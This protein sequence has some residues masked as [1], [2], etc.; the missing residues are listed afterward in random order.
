MITL[1]GDTSTRSREQAIEIKDFKGASNTLLD[2]ARI[3]MNEAKKALNLM[4]V[5]DGLW[6]P[7]WGR[8]YYGATHAASIDGAYEFVKADG[9]TELITIAG[10][11]VYKST[12]GGAL[13]SVSGA[14]FTAGVQLYFLQ[15]SGYLYITNGVDTLARYDGSVLTTYTTLAAP[16]SLTASITGSGLSSGSFPLYAE[17]TALNDIG[18]TV[19]STEASTTVNKLRDNW[20]V[21]IDK[22]TWSWNTVV[23]ASRYQLY[24]ADESGDE[25]LLTS[26]VTNSFE[27]DGSL[28]LNPY[29]ETPI[30]NTTGAPKFKSMCVSGNR[31]WATNNPDSKFTVYFSGTGQFIDKF[32]DFYGG[33]YINLEKGGREMPTAVVHYQSGQG[34][35]RLTTL[36]RTP[37]GKGAVWQITISTATVGDVS[38]SVPSAVKVVGSFGT[39]SILGVVSTNND[40]LFPNRRGMFS[41]GP[42]KNYYGILRTNELT[43]KIRPTW[44]GLLGEK[45]GEIASYFYD[46]KVF[47]SVPTTSSGNNRTIIYDTER[48]NWTVD[49]SFGA[50]QWLEYTDSEKGNHLLYV[51]IDG[52]QLV[53]VGENIQGD[54]GTAFATDYTSGRIPLNKLWKDFLK[55]NKVFIKLGNPRGTINWEVGGTQRNKPFKALTTATITSTSS[56]TGMGWDL[57]G[58]VLMGNTNGTP[59]TFS[60]S[61]DPHYVKVRKKLRDM[62]LRVTTNNYEADYVLQG[63]IIEG[64][65]YKTKPPTGWKLTT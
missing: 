3:A 49:W 7:R 60:D 50:R 59:S 53:E 14:T 13:T 10:G 57:M 16:A 9:T 28:T 24:L 5:Q 2:E 18:E 62:Q 40:I 31:I 37:E 43:S 15:I 30:S 39:D 26:T 20:N 27:D 23:G 47:I 21:L 36:C 32:S 34:E 4:Q 12:D 35:G 19:G 6:K 64:N 46:A 41:L 63:F 65:F 22:V 61:S 29:V 51:P 58:S 42:E 8:D 33:G 55:V 48:T 1:Q 44:N 11:I 38:F 52:T 56:N 17:V 45:I 25:V 54:F